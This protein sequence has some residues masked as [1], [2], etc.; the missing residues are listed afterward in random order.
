MKENNCNNIL[1]RGV[2]WIGDAVMTMPALRAIK[3]ANPD[4]RIS[5]LVKPWVS[6]LFEK[7]PD[8]DQ[9]ILYSDSYRGISGKFRLAQV[10]RKN[11]FCLAVLFQNAFEAALLAFLAGIKRRV[12]YSRDGRSFL[13]TDA[14]DCDEHARSLH[15]IGYYLNLLD[16]SGIPVKDEIPWIYLGIEE[17][18]AARDRLKNL[19][20][21]VI[22]L[23]P[24]AT[25]GS[26]K[27][28]HPARFSEVAFR[29][30]SELKGNAVIFGGPS[31]TGI[32]EEIERE[33]INFPGGPELKPQLLNM[34][35]RT[36][37]RE[38]ISLISE[39]DLLVTN[40]SGPMHI[41]YAVR[42]PVVAIF[43]S[44][45]PE[46]TGPVGRHDVVIKKSLDCAP[47]LKRECRKKALDCMGMI[48]SEEVFYAVKERVNSKK[49]IFFD[50]DGTLCKDPGYLRR[51]EDFEVFPGLENLSRL[52]ES[53]FLLIG[54]T[55]QSGIARGLVDTDF[56][57]QVNSIF[58]E[59][60]GFD[61]F[62]FCPHH[63][64]EHCPCRKPEPGLLFSAR[65]DYNIDLKKSYVI[66]DRDLD[67]VLAKAAGATGILTRTGQE[68]FSVNAAHTARDIREAVDLILGIEGK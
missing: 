36:D 68:S 61:A 16:K 42:T 50:R 56:V 13:L 54:A 57:K 1:V 8:V 65:E 53:G 66:G 22:G 44:T 40:D 2:N 58:I 62:Y 18:I 31:E 6:P 27:R 7:D 28:W 52:K 3:R 47:C 41:G 25:F 51:M 37:V 48:T 39:C 32:A 55:N 21:P 11:E 49:A 30:I 29:V 63:P 33:F 59:K 19:K 23:N 12:G 64:E 5:L 14:V 4:A 24:G 10:I 20:R 35:G 45:S 9:I 67:M 43:G 60:Y 26:S 15:Q 46:H 17:R 38:L 34:A